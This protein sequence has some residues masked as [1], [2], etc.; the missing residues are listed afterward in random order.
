[1]KPEYF[2]IHIRK[3]IEAVD[4]HRPE[5]TFSGGDF[6]PDLIN[7]LKAYLRRVEEAQIRAVQDRR[8]I[9]RSQSAP[10]CGRPHGK[11]W[12]QIEAARKAKVA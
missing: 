5:P 7:K 2:P 4:R 6:A 12:A 1:M 3:Q 9:V 11:I 8:E 10:G